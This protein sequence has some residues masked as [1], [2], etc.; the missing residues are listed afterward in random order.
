LTEV[1]EEAEFAENRVQQRARLRQA[2]VAGARPL[3]EKCA[4][5]SMKIACGRRHFEAIGVD[6]GVVT[7]ARELRRQVSENTYSRIR[8]LS[9]TS[10]R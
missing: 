8:V 10:A 4:A 1:D 5:E 2:F 6:Y 7:T 9:R 3:L